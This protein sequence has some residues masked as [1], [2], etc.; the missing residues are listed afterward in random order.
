MTQRDAAARLLADPGAAAVLAL[1]NGGGEEA[2]I[3][4]GAVRDALLGRPVRE[5][6]IATTALPAETMRRAAAAGLRAVPTG[7]AHGTVTVVVGGRPFETTTLRRDVATDG[8][9]ALVRFGR[10]W[11]L[12]AE[13]RDF[14]MNAL[15]LDAAG[16]LH[17]PI[18]GLADLRLRRVRFIGEPGARIRED[19]LRILRFF[20]FG[21]GYGLGEPDAAGLAACVEER[22]GLARLSAERI[23][24]EVRKLL[25]APGAGP[26]VAAMA[27]SGIAGPILGGVPRVVRLRRLAALQEALGMPPDPVLRLA[28]LAV[29]VREDAERLRARFRLA[30]AET[31]RIVAAA[32]EPLP[33]DFLA[34]GE[35][36]WRRTLYRS[37]AD[38][39]RDRVLLA[40]ADSGACS[41]RLAEALSLPERWPVPRLPVDGTMLLARGMAPGPAIGRALRAI[42]ERWAEAGFPAGHGALNGFVDDALR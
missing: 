2:R 5:I 12:D 6:D 7:I 28:G 24:Q 15:S 35:A 33:P 10:D 14:T 17:D 9:R 38:T 37:G 23:G 3:V 31:A 16:A 29:F 40:A 39:Y 19:V 1:L 25:A 42:E 41:D 20:R 34:A 4:G 27:D 36:A 18:G 22:A 26:T 11:R 30:N 21:A 13:R 32:A 8:R